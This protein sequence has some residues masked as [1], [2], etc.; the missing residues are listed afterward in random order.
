MFAQ[1]ERDTIIDRVI[2]GMEK[3]PPL[4]RLPRQPATHVLMPD[5]GEAAVVQLIHHVYTADWLGTR[6]IATMLNS[7]GHRTTS[8]TGWPSSRPAP[9]NHPRPGRRPIDT[10]TRV[11]THTEQKTLI[12]ALVDSVKITSPD[13]LIPSTAPPAAAY[14]R[15]GQPRIRHQHHHG[16]GSRNNQLGG[17]GGLEPTTGGL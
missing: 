14:H 11:G 5:N 16:N 1:F 15:G 9:G 13:S 6:A 8:P 4:L 12:E 2:A 7:R 17:A 3:R 10:I